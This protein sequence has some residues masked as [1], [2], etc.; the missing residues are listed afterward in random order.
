MLAF[1]YTHTRLGM[2][3]GMLF[4]LEVLFDSGDQNPFL[5]PPRPLSPTLFC[6]LRHC[7]NSFTSS[8]AVTGSVLV[9]QKLLEIVST[10]HRTVQNPKDGL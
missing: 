2:S 8:L 4:A 6:P 9:T 5:S 7:L 1:T 3:V 10:P